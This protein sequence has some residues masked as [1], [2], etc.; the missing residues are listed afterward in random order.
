M[1]E[2]DKGFMRRAIEL[3]E[4]TSLVD[5][6]GGV[7]GTVIVDRNGQIL[8]EGSN[9]VVAENDPTWHG[10]IEAIRKACKKV[11]SFKLTGCTLYSSAECCPKVPT[12]WSPRTIRPGM[13]RSRRSVRPARR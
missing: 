6:A 3:S 9:R 11:G 2:K 13:A 10:E 1:T 8:S 7:F 4:K 5:K 12:A